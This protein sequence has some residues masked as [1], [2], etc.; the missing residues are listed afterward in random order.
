MREMKNKE[1]MGVFRFLLAHSE[2]E[3][4]EFSTSLISGMVQLNGE[5]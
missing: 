4:L 2:T 1:E 3:K 5:E